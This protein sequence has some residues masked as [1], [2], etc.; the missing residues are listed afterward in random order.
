MFIW[1]RDN[2]GT[3]VVLLIV[4]LIVGL[5]IKNM[6]HKKKQGISSCGCGCKEC[7]MSSSCNSKKL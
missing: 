4:I 3:I 5:I 7:P 6:I 2:I 1:L